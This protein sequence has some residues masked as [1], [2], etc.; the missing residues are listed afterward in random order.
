MNNDSEV[1][2][3]MKKL[4]TLIG[5]ILVLGLTAC[6]GA[7]G[8]SG[9]TSGAAGA[10]TRA[11]SAVTQTGPLD[12]EYRDA[13]PVA[14]QLALGTLSLENTNLSVSTEQAAELLPLWQVVQSLD[15][16]GNV[17]EVE[18]SAVVKQLEGVM[19][20]EQIAAIAAMQLTAEKVQEMVDNGTLQLGRGGA[21]GAGAAGGQGPGAGRG[22]GG[23]FLGGGPGGGPGG[24]LG[25]FDSSVMETRQAELEA[26]GE[27]PLTAIL[28]RGS[29]GMVVRLLQ[30]KLGQ[31]PA[32]EDGPYGAVVAAIGE[33]TGLSLEEI[34][35]QAA[36]GKTLAEIV[37]ENGGDEEAVRAAAAATLEKGALPDG[38][39]VNTIVEQMLN[40]TFG[41]G[42][43]PEAS[44]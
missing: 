15:T 25:G 29:A 16:D 26:S 28:S 22:I 11:V 18:M 42:R 12:Q 21:G 9:T 38:Q 34:Q 40:G 8:A 17:A 6:G 24:D 3:I 1:K 13:L 2:K 31:A 20:G 32:F 35:G 30:T 5:V 43:L 33:A 36:E 4:G 19:S 27:S 39:D 10:V 37:T 14:Q 44:E 23:G 7:T 41:G